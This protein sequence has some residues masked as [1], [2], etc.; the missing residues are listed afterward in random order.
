[1]LLQQNCRVHTLSLKKIVIKK[2]LGGGMQPY[3]Y[4]NCDLQKLL[5]SYVKSDFQYGLSKMGIEA[6]T[7]HAVL[8]NQ[9]EAWMWS[10]TRLCYGDLMW[11]SFEFV[12]QILT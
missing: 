3:F 7:C 5:C 4:D 9:Q 2:Y 1:M 10:V 6:V 8:N 12:P 11:P